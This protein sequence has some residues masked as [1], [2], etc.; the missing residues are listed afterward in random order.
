MQTLRKLRTMDWKLVFFALRRMCTVAGAIAIGAWFAAERHAV[1]LICSVLFFA[2]VW[3]MAFLVIR[4]WR[5]QFARP[6]IHKGK[7]VGI[8]RARPFPT[9]L[10]EVRERLN[11]GIATT[12]D[13]V[14]RFTLE[15]AVAEV[16]AAMH[17]LSGRQVGA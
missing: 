14:V 7:R 6:E 9:T 13:E 3:V 1:E 11:Q 5:V 12:E 4:A 16:D 10:P 15:G 2:L 8:K 17:Q